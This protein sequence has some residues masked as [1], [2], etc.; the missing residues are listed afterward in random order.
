MVFVAALMVIPSLVIEFASTSA[1]WTGVGEVL[2]W[3]SWSVFL[4]EIVVMLAVVEDRR[5]WLRE[6]RLDVVITVVTFPLLAGLFA[7]LRLFRLARLASVLRLLRLLRAAN[8]I[9]QIATP[10]GLIWSGFFAL[11]AVFVGAISFN[12][13]ESG[14]EKAPS[15]S[16]ALWWAAATTTTVGY[17]D[18]VPRTTAG[19]VIAVILMLVGIGLVALLTASIAAWAARAGRKEEE[20][21][22]ADNTVKELRK[23]FQALTERVAEMDVTLREIHTATTEH[24]DQLE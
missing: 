2:N 3:V 19:R 24:R 15:V 9:N 1:A 18:I 6:H 13:A 20:Q 21:D 10:A 17:G 5:R 16:D 12:L 7:L 22:I 8:L 11:I 23:D 4:L 14:V